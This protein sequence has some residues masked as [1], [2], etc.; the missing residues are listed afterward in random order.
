MINLKY[1]IVK[2]DM[3]TSKFPYNKVL[4]LNYKRDIEFSKRSHKIIFNIINS[5]KKHKDFDKAIKEI[6]DAISMLKQEKP[7]EFSPNLGW[8]EKQQL[9][10]LYLA[11]R[12]QLKD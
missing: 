6:E 9:V 11:D 3:L 12:L 7:E 10:E 5:Y 1:N 2:E 4:Q 8:F